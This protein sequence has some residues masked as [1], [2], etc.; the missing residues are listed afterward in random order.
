[1]QSTKPPWL[2]EGGKASSKWLHQYCS[3]DR[4]EISSRVYLD[5]DYRRGIS[6]LSGSR[7]LSPFQG[8]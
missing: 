2:S 3:V 5:A 6:W 7:R 8:R 1:M 4:K